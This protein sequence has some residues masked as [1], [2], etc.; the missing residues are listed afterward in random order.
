MPGVAPAQ[1]YSRNYPAGASVGHLLGYVGTASAKDYQER[2]DP[3]LIT[4]GYKVGKEGLEKSFERQLTGQPGAKRVEVTARGKVVRELTTRTDTPGKSIQLSIDA[5]LQEYA[6][7]RLGT[8]SGSVVVLD[9]LTG[10][11]LAMASMP[12]FDPNSF[13]DGISHQIGRAHV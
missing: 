6:G 1:G 8:Q 3:L 5:G 12:S 7:R 9:C 4:P 10:D 11:M 2:K 13:S